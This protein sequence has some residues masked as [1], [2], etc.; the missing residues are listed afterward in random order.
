MITL[1]TSV[2]EHFI[3]VDVSS[4]KLDLYDQH[5]LSHKII[6]NAQAE[7]E[8]FVRALVRM[9]VQPF[10][11][12]EATGRYEMLLVETLH[13]HGIQCAV[14]NPLQIRNFARGCGLL[15]KSDK[16]DAKIIAKFAE[17]VRPKAKTPPSSQL[18]KLRALVHRRNQILLQCAS[19]KNRLQ[20]TTEEEAKESIKD[21]IEFYKQQLRK[22]DHRIKETIEQCEEM[23][24]EAAILRT[25]PGV[26][27]VTIGMLLAELPELGQLNRGQIAKLVGVAPLARD[28]GKKSGQRK[29]FA[30]RAL[31]RKVLYMAA[32]TA[33][34]F[35]KPLKTFYNRLISKGKPKKLAIV[36]VMRKLLVTL[37]SMIKNQKVWCETALAIDKN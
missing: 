31:V 11:V 6:P 34:R 21:A 4:Q 27:N 15:E 16:I 18:S 36:A 14:V 30:G 28:S 37:N 19:E 25:C 24:R 10:V 23:S 13:K 5:E 8:N 35:N 22:F 9:E 17:V 7:V 20:Q 1:S 3:G 29:T 12:M 26:G 32:L 2:S 33:T